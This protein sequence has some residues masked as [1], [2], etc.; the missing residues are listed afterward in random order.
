M[1]GEALWSAASWFWERWVFICQIGWDFRW[2]HI[3]N[4]D[5]FRH[6]D[7]SEDEERVAQPHI[8]SVFHESFYALEHLGVVL[9]TY[10]FRGVIW[11]Y[12]NFGRCFMLGILD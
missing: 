8:D 1:D 9:E 7:P 5:G 3:I 11:S 6:I 12:T 4:M 10:Q 2:T